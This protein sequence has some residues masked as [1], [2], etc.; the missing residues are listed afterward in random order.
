MIFKP[1]SCKGSRPL[2]WW[3]LS[4]YWRRTSIEVNVIKGDLVHG[5]K[6]DADELEL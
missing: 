1:A 6:P 3:R 4:K 5:L 2:E